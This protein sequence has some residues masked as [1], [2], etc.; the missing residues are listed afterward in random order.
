MLPPQSGH[1]QFKMPEITSELALSAPHLV[2]CIHPSTNEQGTI[3][4]LS[5]TFL[6]ISVTTE[7]EGKVLHAFRVP[8]VRREVLGA[9]FRQAM[10]FKLKTRRSCPSPH[11]RSIWQCAKSDSRLRGPASPRS[12]MPLRRRLVLSASLEKK[13]GRRGLEKPSQYTA[14]PQVQPLSP[15]L[16]VCRVESELSTCG[17][18]VDGATLY[19][20]FVRPSHRPILLMPLKTRS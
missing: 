6:H 17:H 9:Q 15:V 12:F 20:G 18:C 1:T 4:W 5:A 2:I 14:E 7:A 10:E 13:S 11:Q 16:T 3:S 19:L 8:T